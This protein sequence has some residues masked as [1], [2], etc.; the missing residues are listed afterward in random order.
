MKRKKERPKEKYMATQLQKYNGK[1]ILNNEITINYKTKKVNFTPVKEN[2]NI[3]RS[4][5]THV[6]FSVLAPS[7]FISFLFWHI[8]HIDSLDLLSRYAILSTKSFINYFIASTIPFYITALITLPL[9]IQ[10]KLQMR[11][12]KWRHEIFPKINVSIHQWIMKLFSLGLAKTNKRIYKDKLGTTIIKKEFR[13][14]F[15][16]YKATED[17]HT[18]LE[19]IKISSNQHAGKS[20][21]WF[22]EFIFKKEPQKGHLTIKYI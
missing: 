6:M 11:N 3:E 12:Q 17:Y 8:Y 19:K 21:D 2:F 4:Y 22:L 9:L 20:R 7:L 16:D 15:L 10:I 14:V 1:N 13:N 18:F 5:I